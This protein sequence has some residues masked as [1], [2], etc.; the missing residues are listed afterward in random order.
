MD[1]G[2]R[3]YNINDCEPDLKKI[4]SSI[5]GKTGFLIAKTSPMID[6]TDTLRQFDSIT[7]IWII[8]LRNECK[9]LLFKFTFQNEGKIRPADTYLKL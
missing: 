6:I 1:S 3:K 2:T 5:S 9:E 7:D 4:I 8:S